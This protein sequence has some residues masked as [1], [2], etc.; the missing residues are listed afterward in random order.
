MDYNYRCMGCMQEQLDFSIPCPHCGYTEQ[1]NKAGQLP[2]RSFLL[3]KYIIGKSLGAG[4]FGITY[5]GFDIHLLKRVCIKEF[6]LGGISWRDRDGFT[7]CCNAEY[8]QRFNHEKS[9][10][11]EE[12]RVLAQ[13]DDQPG[14]VKVLNYFE[15]NQTAYIVMDYVEGKSLR[16]YI[17]EHGGKLSPVETFS[18]LRPVVQALATMHAKGIVHLDISPSNIMLT[19]RGVAKLIDF[20]AAKGRNK[21]LNSDKVF[22]KTYSPIEQRTLD[23]QIGTYSDVYALCATFYEIL[24]GQRAVGSLER[25]AGT[26]MYSPR[27]YGIGITSEQEQAIISG[28]A[29]DPKDR[30]QSAADLYFYLYAQDDMTASQSNAFH[31]AIQN[32]HAGSQLVLNALAEEKK[33]RDKNKKMVIGIS[34]T[35]FT[36]IVALAV[37]LLVVKP[38]SNSDSS[39]SVSTTVESTTDYDNTSANLTEITPSL[40]TASDDA[41]R[42]LVYSQIDSVRAGDGTS[43]ANINQTYEQVATRISDKCIETPNP[44]SNDWNNTLQAY[45]NDELAN[46]NLS[47]N[48]WLL[49]ATPSN[50]EVQI[51]SE[52][53]EQIDIINN[54]A[55]GAVTLRNCSNLGISV[56]SHAN[57]QKYWIVIFL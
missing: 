50:D 33:R 31:A 21:D 45:I 2:V 53:E 36:V 29:I 20:G 6:Y 48:G 11:I 55:A 34:A 47:Q 43:A 37:V 35:A 41:L 32:S 44:G 8:M 26:P 13:L 30:I 18:L 14:V 28:L 27:Q 52:L 1:P 54:N 46:A 49:Y 4:G 7:V 39:S 40:D 15:A 42:D 56:R 19:E 16:S 12:A 51:V 9:R 38:F 10:F 22:K 3:N 5:I 25:Q 23:G 57:G 24:T 17:N